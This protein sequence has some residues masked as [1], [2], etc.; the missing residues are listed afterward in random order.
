MHPPAYLYDAVARGEVSREL[1]D[2]IEREH[3]AAHCPTCA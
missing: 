1:L 2:E 3:L